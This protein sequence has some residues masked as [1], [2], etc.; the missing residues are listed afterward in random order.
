MSQ[1]S[2]RRLLAAA[3]A[4]AI[5][6]AAGGAAALWPRA[7]PGGAAP[8]DAGLVPFYG[9]RQ[10]GVATPVQDR[11][12][13]AAFDVVTDSR[14]QLAALL[15]TWTAAAA[16]MAAGRPVGG[17]GRAA[18]GSVPDDSGEAIGLP[19]ARLTLTVGFGPSLFER[20]GEDRFGLAGRRPPALAD[21]PAFDGD[22]LDPARCGGDIAVQAC[23]DDPQVAVHAI[24]TLARLGLGRVVVRWS[25]L[26]YGKTSSTTPGQATPRNLMGFKDGTDNIAGDDEAAL[27]AHVW[28][29][30]GDGPDWMTGGTYLVARRIRMHLE[31]WDQAG[32]DEQERVIGRTKPEG[33]PLGGRTERDAFDPAGLPADAHVRLAH[34]SSNGGVRILRRGYSFV[35]GSDTQGRIDAGLFFI[36]FQR[37]PRRQF[38]PLQRRLAAQDRLS[39]YIRHVGSGVWAC[40]PGVRPDGYW[41]DTLLA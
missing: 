38:V 28:A 16:S 36:A 19:A 24:R 13:F 3:G 35:D 12:H 21:L 37:D 40:P 31:A 25:Q 29:A 10:A 27:A 17:G 2:R 9:A 8:E 5:A 14:D 6:G 22:H 39:T 7:R 32:L 4:G 15:R 20:G 18:P 11:L 23:A 30:P 33:A 26:G 1:V 41:G 34:P